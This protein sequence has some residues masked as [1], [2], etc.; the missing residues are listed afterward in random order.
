MENNTVSIW[1]DPTRTSNHFGET[2]IY[3]TVRAM[4]IKNETSG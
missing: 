1:L 4:T 2:P 3:G